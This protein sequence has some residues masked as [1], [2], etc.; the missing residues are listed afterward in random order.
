MICGAIGPILAGMVSDYSGNYDSA[1]MT[2]AVL[3]ALGLVLVLTLPKTQAA[4]A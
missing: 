4:T 1:F 2:L 3:M